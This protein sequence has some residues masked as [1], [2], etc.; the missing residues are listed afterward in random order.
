MEKNI[1]NTIVLG[2]ESPDNEVIIEDP[3]E[4]RGG[5]YQDES[6]LIGFV[7]VD[8]GSVWL[9]DPSYVI[10]PEGRSKNSPSLG[11]DWNEFCDKL[12]DEDGGHRPYRSFP[13]PMGHEGLGVWVHTRSGDGS[14]PVYQTTDDDGKITGVY[15]DFTRKIY[16][17]SKI[18]PE[19]SESV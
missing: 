13:Y 5:V 7:G 2:N 17:N 12:K 19:W 9:G 1:E 18:R 11:N 3:N 16:P 14:Y 8:T 15:V 10:H 4:I 6:E